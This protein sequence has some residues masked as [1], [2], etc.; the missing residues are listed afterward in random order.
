MTSSLTG[1]RPAAQPLPGQA[2]REPTAPSTLLWTPLALFRWAGLLT[3]AFIVIV[4]CWY[5][6]SGKDNW[7]D[8][9]ASMNLALAALLVAQAASIGLLLAGRRTIGL[10]RVALLGEASADYVPDSSTAAD[11]GPVA[12][13]S[14]DLLVGESGRAHYHRADCPM[15]QGRDWPQATELEMQR[16]GMTPCGVCRP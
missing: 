5:T 15:A 14:S 7:I 12:A 8:Q 10:R 3:V 1:R 4:A 9:T 2:Q 13:A 6:I 16:A 11:A